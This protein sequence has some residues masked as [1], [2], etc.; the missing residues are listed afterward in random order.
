MY[1]ENTAQH[2]LAGV[3]IG[4]ALGFAVGSLR[5]GDRWVPIQINGTESAFSP[6]VR[7]DF[8]GPSAAAIGLRLRL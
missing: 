1:Y 2:L 8:H 6:I 7:L 5:S 4:G 3:V